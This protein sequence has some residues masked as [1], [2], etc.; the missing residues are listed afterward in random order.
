MTDAPSRDELPL[1]DY[2]HLPLGS[3]A[4]RIRTLDADQLVDV[5]PTS[6]PTA[7]GYR[8]PR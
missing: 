6:A 3:L 4:A 1:P 5:L 8:S 7:I 2:D